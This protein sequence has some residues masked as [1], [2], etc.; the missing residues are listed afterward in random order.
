MQD[1]DY[2]QWP[3]EDLLAFEEYAVSLGV[4]EEERPRL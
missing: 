1:L 4:V 3:G 2:E